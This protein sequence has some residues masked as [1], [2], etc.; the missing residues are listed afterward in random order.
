MQ[1]AQIPQE[2]REAI[3]N[4]AAQ[5]RGSDLAAAADQISRSYRAGLPP[6]LDTPVA[7]TAYLA[8]R[9]PATFG[10]LSA[11]ASELPFDPDS[12]LDLGAGPGT[13]AWVAPCA[14]TLVEQN[15]GWS[16]A[17]GGAGLQPAREVRRLQADI[18]RLPPLDQHDFVSICYALNELAPKDRQRVLADAWDLASR[19]L[20]ILEP[21]TMEGFS[22]V[23]EARAQLISLGAA[24]QAP[25]PH[26]AEC[27]MSDGDWCH[28]A[29]RVERTRLH[30][31]LKGGDLS[32][33]DEKYSYVLALKSEVNP[34]DARILR[35]PH[36]HPGLIEL[37]LCTRANGLQ[38]ARVTKKD[39]P[40]WRAARKA[41]WGGRW[42]GP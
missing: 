26:A 20:L 21:G 28:F 2:L 33:E 39:K 3:E 10:A 17:E 31:S 36:T 29:V 32:Y 16:E 27:P 22:I 40:S 37:Q 14:C 12:W 18:T 35:H 38:P 4:Q 6:R 7:R 15:P 34:C 30:R 23:R 5:F 11:A 25:C 1:T 42:G 24:I 9:M 13:A 41:D 19:A 8:T